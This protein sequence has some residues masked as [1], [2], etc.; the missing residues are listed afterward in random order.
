MTDVSNYFDFVIYAF[1]ITV[2][3]IFILNIF[4]RFRRKLNRVEFMLIFSIIFIISLYIF[5]IVNY[6]K[7]FSKTRNTERVVGIGIISQAVQVYLRDYAY[8][9]KDL[10]NIPLCPQVNSIGD[11]A[12]SVNLQEKLKDISLPILP[13]DPLRGNMG[14]SGYTICLTKSSRVK[15]DAPYAENNYLIYSEK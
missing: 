2:G 8:D 4:F 12:G 15:I 3:L 11:A 7:D 6:N 10:G 13:V 9:L 5:T 1:F 14:N